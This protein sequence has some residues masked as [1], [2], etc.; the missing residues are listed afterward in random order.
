MLEVHSRMRIFSVFSQTQSELIRRTS[1]HEKRKSSKICEIVSTISVRHMIQMKVSHSI[2]IYSIYKI[3]DHLE[4][5]SS[6]SLSLRVSSRRY[7]L[8]FQRLSRTEHLV[9]FVSFSRNHLVMMSDQLA[10]SSQSLGCIMMR[11]SFIFSI[12]TWGKKVCDP[13]SHSVRRTVS[14]TRSSIRER[15]L[16]SRYQHLRIFE[17]EKGSGIL[18]LSVSSVIWSSPISSKCS[19]SSH[20]LSRVR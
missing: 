20:S 15:L 10:P 19:H 8:I 7:C 6:I 3:Q 18:T 13:S 9:I 16:A 12:T 4:S 14:S 5:S 2:E 11:V 1:L 17:S